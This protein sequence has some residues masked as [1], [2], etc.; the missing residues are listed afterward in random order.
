MVKLSDYSPRKLSALE[1]F[2]LLRRRIIGYKN[3]DSRKR[4]YIARA[5]ST[6]RK[7]DENNE[8]RKKRGGRNNISISLYYAR[9]QKPS[10]P[11]RPS[12]A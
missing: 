3:F 4:L 7:S 11:R 12:A 10:L 8:D 6:R 5:P 9:N 2:T 1:L